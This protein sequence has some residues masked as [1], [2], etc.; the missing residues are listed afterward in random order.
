MANLLQREK[1]QGTY[2]PV[3]LGDQTDED[4]IIK[5]YQENLE[6]KKRYEQKYWRFD[7]QD[8]MEGGEFTDAEFEKEQKTHHKVFTKRNG[9]RGI[10]HF[11][12]S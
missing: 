3:M 11:L 8:A 9:V 1:L 7:G 6:M 5:Q 12:T 4:F 10:L 2:A